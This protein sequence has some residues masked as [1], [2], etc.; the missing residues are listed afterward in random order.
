[1]FTLLHKL[2]LLPLAVAVT[3]LGLVAPAGA[4]TVRAPDVKPIDRPVERPDER[5]TD[6]DVLS[7][8]CKGEV[9]EGNK[10]AGCRWSSSDNARA[11]QLWRIVNRGHRELVGTYDNTTNIA[12][13]DVPDDAV[14]V[15]YAVL[16]LGKDG[17]IVGRSRVA[18]VR[19]RN[20]DREIDRTVDRTVDR[21]P[22]RHAMLVR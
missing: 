3:V 11:Y 21:V 6:I 16:A 4:E 22:V 18:R 12:R 14:L 10:V 8:G 17:E 1:M 9:R 19:F 5:P 20:H 15:R 7:I 13:D 2:W